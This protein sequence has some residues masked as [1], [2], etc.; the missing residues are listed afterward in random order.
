MNKKSLLIVMIIFVAVI[1]FAVV[2]YNYL[3]DNFESRIPQSDQNESQTKIPARDFTVYD[4]IGNEVSLSNIKGKPVVVNFWATWCGP[5]RSEMP[6][7]DELAKKYKDDVVFLMINIDESDV[8]EFLKENNY[9]F[10][11]YYDLD[12]SASNAYAVSS[13]PRTVFIDEEGY[14]IAYYSGAMNE[15][16]LESYIGLLIG[17]K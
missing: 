10:D 7:F 14:E 13:I 17:E 9:S 3:S 12:Y 1:V 2:G 5:C 4:S 6:Y 16:T 11:V 15:K 8:S